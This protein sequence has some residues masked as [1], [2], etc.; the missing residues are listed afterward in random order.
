MNFW[1]DLKRATSG[2]DGLVWFLDEQV[3]HVGGMTISR[4]FCDYNDKLIIRGLF[5]PDTEWVVDE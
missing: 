1:R 2:W 3:N 4:R 5:G